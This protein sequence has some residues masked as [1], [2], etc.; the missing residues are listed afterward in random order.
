VVDLV[1]EL[2]GEAEPG[3]DIIG[4]GVALA[5]RV[6]GSTGT[7]F[8]SPD[9]QSDGCYWNAVPLEA[10]LEDSIRARA[11]DGGGATRVVVENDANALGM[12]E[13]L[14][15]GEDQSICIVLM[16]ESGEGIGAG[17]V[18]NHAIAHGTGGVSG[19]IGHVIVDPGGKACRCGNRGCL[20]AVA[21]PAAIVRK[22]SETASA[23]NLAEVSAL[24][25]RGDRAA[26]EVV[27]TAG[28]ALGRVLSNVSAIL[29]P[30]RLVIFGPPEL[31]Q[32]PDLPSART[33]LDG[34]RRAHGQAMLGV[35]VNIESRVL[36]VGTLSEAAAATA[37]HHFL[38]RPQRWV[39]AIADPGPQ[40]GDLTSPQPP[41]VSR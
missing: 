33:F 14:R 20:E 16:S 17:L 2:R 36:E 22:I 21:S 30:E 12:Y 18:V 1:E 10:D 28:E 38:A 5:G 39:P 35:K 11:V 3:R 6:D 25:E 15:Q 8:F 40:R 34:V 41:A 32:E 27:G 7:V 31:T 13:Y 37:V 23:K 4:L 29:G 26:D 24:V 9:L 19:E